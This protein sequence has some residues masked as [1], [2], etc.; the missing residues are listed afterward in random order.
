VTEHRRPVPAPDRARIPREALTRAGLDPD[1]T[2][3]PVGALIPPNL[4]EGPPSSAAMLAAVGDALGRTAPEPGDE[5]SVGRVQALADLLA[6]G[7][8]PQ[9]GPRLAEGYAAAHESDRDVLLALAARARLMRDQ[10]GPIRDLAGREVPEG[11]D[12]SARQM[13]TGARGTLN[14]VNG[15][16]ELAAELLAHAAFPHP[17]P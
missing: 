4:G 11:C 16:L 5:R 15:D 12:L 8:D 7:A 10:L 17:H 2:A 1:T 13:I 9:A 14:R 3:L 6:A